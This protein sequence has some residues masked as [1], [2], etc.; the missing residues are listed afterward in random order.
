IRMLPNNM[1]LIPNS[2]L[3]QSIITNYYLP[4]KRM[5]LLIRVGVSYDADPEHV[6]RV[7]LEVAKSAV[8]EIPGLLGEPEPFVRF[9]PGFGDSSLDFTLICQVREFVDQYL[10]Q[11]ELRK[12]IFK[13]FKEEGIEIPFPHRTVYLREEKDWQK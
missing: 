11:H 10:V 3:A 8:G 2:K 7:L 13:R 1:V 9:I 12:R 6:E 4:F 5:S